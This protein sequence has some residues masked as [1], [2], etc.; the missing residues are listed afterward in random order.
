M[1]PNQHKQLARLLVANLIHREMKVD[2]L[3]HVFS[4]SDRMDVSDEDYHAVEQAVGRI[5]EKLLRE[6]VQFTTVAEIINYVVTPA[7]ASKEDET[8]D[9]YAFP[10]GEI[11]N[12]LQ[13]YAKERKRK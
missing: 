7:K 1:T 13:Y 6:D 11:R 8:G 3:V 12:D 9:D 4:A 10:P 2:G 5:Y